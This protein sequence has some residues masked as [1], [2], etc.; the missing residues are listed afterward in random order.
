[1]SPQHIPE[2]VDL[3]DLMP[4]GAIVEWPSDRL[5]SSRWAFCNGQTYSRTEY[6]KLF[7]VCGDRYGGDGSTT[8]AVPDKRGRVAVHPSGTAPFA[9]AGDTGG[10]QSG[11]ATTGGPSAT[12][13]V[14][15]TSLNASVA[16]NAHTHSVSYSTLQ[17]YVV[18]PSIIKIV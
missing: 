13:L 1:M 8:F 5:P 14:S 15:T 2:T 16:S 9:A 10:V 11:S 6:A 4:V 7:G 12:P 18:L 17:P 3:T